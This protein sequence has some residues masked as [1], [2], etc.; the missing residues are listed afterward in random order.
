MMTTSREYQRTHIVMPA[1]IPGGMDGVISGLVGRY[2]RNPVA[3]GGLKREAEMIDRRGHALGSLSG[4]A[5]HH[6]LQELKIRFRREGR[7]KRPL[8]QD[9][10]ATL[11]EAAYRTLGMRPYPVQ[12][13]GALALNRGWLA[14]MATGEGKTL[15]VTLPAVLAGWT[16]RPCHVITA[17]DYLA[18]RDVA[19]M[20]PLFDYCGLSTG[21]VTGEMMPEERK[22]S[23]D[24]GV[25]Y[26]TSKEILADFLRDR[27]KM[28]PFHHASRRLI[29]GLHRP[30]AQTPDGV[31]MRGI[32]TAFVDEA[33]SVLIDEAVT[34][35]IIS[36]ARENPLLKEVILTAH[37]MAE[38]LERFRHYQVDEKRRDIFLTEAGHDVLERS[39]HR[40]K[41]MWQGKSRQV[42][43]LKQTLCARELYHRDQHYVVQE[44]TIIIV[45]AFTGRLMP[46]RTW[47]HGLH[48][49]VEMKEG[50]AMTDPAETLARLSFQQF[51]RFFRHLAGMT[52][53]GQ[54]AASEF[55]HI[56]TLPYVSIPTHRPCIRTLARD[57][58]FL[59]RDQK[60]AAVVAEIVRAHRMDRPVLVGTRSVE[61]S[62]V[63]AERLTSEGLVFKVL[64]AVRH[65]DE[66]Q[67]VAGAGEKGS[68]TIATNMAGRG[69]D[70]KLGSGVVELGGLHVIATERH[71]TGRVD[72]QLF[73]RC[74]RQGNPGSAQAF[75]SLDDE[76]IRN[77][78]P[79]WASTWLSTALV[80]KVPGA[81]AMVKK[82]CLSAQ[83]AAE[84]QA[85]RQRKNVLK[86]DAWMAE[87]LSFTG[88]ESF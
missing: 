73:G 19:E 5:L 33:D 87:A 69:T 72:R 30:G 62:E 81:C 22:A 23:Y 3:V 84:R 56:Y 25:V 67:I 39:A 42:E 83:R 34:P 59:N 64:N 37:E 38:S 26:T 28:A 43:L 75:I 54:E 63:L 1:S 88:S 24:C 36:V 16:G 53:T 32:D 18:A 8:V 77:K 71:E 41:G 47:S 31:V 6:R 86:N 40:L 79:G 65:A 44:G 35:L 4:G 82:V 46:H 50:V 12:L 66:A 20:R 70:I 7:D 58:V 60:W 48:Q 85:Y 55:W 49:A 80:A 2:R 13:M 74:A 57:A 15:T 17:N 27:L 45:D 52:G 14:E 10:L 61:E 68:I 29:R 21:C 9:A 11:S 51:F 76:L 78:A